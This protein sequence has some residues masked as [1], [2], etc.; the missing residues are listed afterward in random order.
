M[1]ASLVFSFGSSSRQFPFNP[2]SLTFLRDAQMQLRGDVAQ[3]WGLPD[4]SPTFFLWSPAARR[5]QPGTLA[6]PRSDALTDQIPVEADQEKRKA[7][8][9]EVQKTPAEDLPYLFLWF[10]NVVSVHRRELGDLDV[11]PTGDYDFRARLPCSMAAS[12]ASG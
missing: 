7:L 2:A 12:N 8:C 4:L 3:S 11:S 5:R 9:S 10:T 1:L 6:D